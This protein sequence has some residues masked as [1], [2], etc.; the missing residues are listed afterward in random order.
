MSAIDI[1]RAVIN[2]DTDA[3]VAECNM[4]LDARSQELLNQGTA[5]VLDSIASDMNSNDDGQ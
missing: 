4:E 5:Y 3:A 1:V 2:G